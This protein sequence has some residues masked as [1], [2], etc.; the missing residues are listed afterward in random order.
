MTNPSKPNP[1]RALAGAA[2][3]SILAPWGAAAAA[4]GVGP[5]AVL[6]QAAADKPSVAVLAGLGIAAIVA[7]FIVFK[8]AKAMIITGLILVVLGGLALGVWWYF[9]VRQGAP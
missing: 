1:G 3:I 6:A 7:L 2:A 4:G 8:V 5:M 9:R